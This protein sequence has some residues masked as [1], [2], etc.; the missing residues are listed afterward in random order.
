MII[1]D[2]WSVAQGEV[3]VATQHR[4]ERGHFLFALGDEDAGHGDNGDTLSV[5]P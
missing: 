5:H 1:Q 4:V 3:G 2:G